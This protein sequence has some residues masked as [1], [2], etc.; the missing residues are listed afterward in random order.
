VPGHFAIEVSRTLRSQ[1]R[2]KLLTD[3][4]V[5]EA[6]R[7]LADIPLQQDPDDA[8]EHIAEIVTLARTHDMRVADAAYVELSLRTG[9]ALA[10]RDNAL[11]VA[12]TKAGAELFKR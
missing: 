10:T 9:F 8:L 5:E 6:L 3:G 7:R 4:M 12:A 1:E 2:R 11:A